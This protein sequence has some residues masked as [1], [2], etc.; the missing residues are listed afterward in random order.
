VEQYRLVL[1]NP[2][3]RPVFALGFILKLAVIAIPIVLAL[4]VAVGLGKGM[5]TAGLAVSAWL[6][7]VTAGSPLQGA[8]IDRWGLRPVL[9]LSASA[10]G[11]FWEAAPLL[12]FPALLAGAAV[13]GVLLIPGSTPV[14]LAIT[15]LIPAGQRQTGFAIDSMLTE[16]SYI[17]GPAA[18]ALAT[19]Q[20]SSTVAM[21]GLGCVAVA[22]GL[23]LAMLPHRPGE[24]APG[25]PGEAGQEARPDR[26]MSVIALLACVIAAGV[27]T[28]GFEISLVGLM[29]LAGTIRWMG[30]LLSAC[31]VYALVGGFVF[32]AS[33]LAVRTWVTTLLLG[34]VVAPLGW[35]GDWRVLLAAVAPAAVLSAVTLAA[36]AN[37]I[38]GIATAAT[39]GRVMS[40]YGAALAGGN[41]VGSPL[42][43]LAVSMG[44]AAAGFVTVGG[45]AIAVSLAARLALQAKTHIV[46]TALADDTVAAPARLEN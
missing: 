28:G 10:Q 39:R 33:R 3:V 29:R 46:P 35:V 14:R 11:V 12:G 27:A 22:G 34:L 42:A 1:N 19:T 9:L 7:G 8:A 45:V 25:A 40:V 18:G 30:L 5:G 43:G 2:G 23:S 26:W 20:I 41:A 37:E 31:G 21:R 6:I 15:T 36:A 38:S 24:P 13:S 44:G 16:L 4:H 32:G 17:A